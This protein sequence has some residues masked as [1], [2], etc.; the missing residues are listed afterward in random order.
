MS[1]LLSWLLKG[2]D[3]SLCC[4]E[5]VWHGCS[6]EPGIFSRSGSTSGLR[7]GFSGPASPAVSRLVCTELLLVGPLRLGVFEDYHPPLNLDRDPRLPDEWYPRHPPFKPRPMESATDP[8]GIPNHPLL[9]HP[10]DSH[11]HLP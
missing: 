11:S 4:G 5:F 9:T 8:L 10:L 3:H 1:P 7:G 2:M 6:S